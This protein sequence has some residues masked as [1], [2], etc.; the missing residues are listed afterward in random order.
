M[1]FSSP[2]FTFFCVQHSF[3]RPPAFWSA[4]YPG[5][6]LQAFLITYSLPKGSAASF[7]PLFVGSPQSP[8]RRQPSGFLDELQIFF[9]F[10]SF[11][12]FPHFSFF[13]LLGAQ[14]GFPFFFFTT[15]FRNLGAKLI[16]PKHRHYKKINNCSLF[17]LIA[18]FSQAWPIRTI[19]FLQLFWDLWSLPILFAFY[20]DYKVYNASH[21]IAFLPCY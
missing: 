4:L 14:N 7:F 15:S 10:R 9:F 2:S 12:Y 5:R 20:I 3:T 21:L 18:F 17:L 6:R 1:A 11:V 13:S 16:M 8:S 19:S